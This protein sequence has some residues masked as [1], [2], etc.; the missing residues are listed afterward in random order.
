MRQLR[1]LRQ[2]LLR[3][4]CDRSVLS[5]GHLAR[6]SCNFHPNHQVDGAEWNDEPNINISNPPMH[7]P[8]G[9]IARLPFTI[10]EQI[11]QRLRDG[12][13]STQILPWLNQLPEVQSILATQFGGRPINK[14]NLS[15]WRLNAYRFW[16]MNREALEFK[17]THPHPHT[18]PATNRFGRVQ[19]SQAAPPRA[20]LDQPVLGSGRSTLVNPGHSQLKAA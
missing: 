3:A 15:A 11:N 10:R 16:L 14:Q 20:G 7:A 8:T 13:M 9:K 1:Q 6:P 17:S 19:P 18:R 12:R 5:L 4:Y 2:E